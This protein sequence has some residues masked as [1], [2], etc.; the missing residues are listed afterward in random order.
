[1]T[2]RIKTTLT[3]AA[4]AIALTGASAMAQS[5][6]T[7]ESRFALGPHLSTLGLGGEAAIKLS[8]RLVLRLGGN[9]F[10]MGTSEGLDGVTYDLDL[11]LAS[12]GG[13]LDLHPFANGFLISAGV[14]WNGNKLDASATPTS[15]VT[16]GGTSFTPAQVGR[17]DGDIEFTPIAPYLGLGWDG[18]FF[19]D[20]ALSLKLRAGLFYMGEPD[21]TLRASGSLAG[22]AALQADLAVEESRIESELDFL[23]FYPAVT[24][25]FTYRF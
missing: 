17:I 3:T 21:V 4:L 6:T 1:M 25:G 10:A 12:A 13:A 23:A 16:I 9:Y 2:A 22:S 24:L 7:T 15:N 19:G 14:F 8:D 20:G 5:E 11:T 18:T